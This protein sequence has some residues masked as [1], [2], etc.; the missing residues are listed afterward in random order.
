MF[1]KH[2]SVLRGLQSTVPFLRNTMVSLCC[3]KATADAFAAGA[4]TFDEAKK[5]LNK[6]PTTLHGVN[7]AVIKL[8]KL[9][10]ATK[11]YRGVSGAVLPDSFWTPNAFNVCGGIESAFER[12]SP[13]GRLRGRDC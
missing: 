8:G 9:T 6:Y 1:V 5:S 10:V 4:I 11:V 12:R 7:S 13:P 2:N 3:P